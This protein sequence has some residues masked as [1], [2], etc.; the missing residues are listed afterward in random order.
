[1]RI[2]PTDSQSSSFRIWVGRA[3]DGVDERTFELPARSSLGTIQFSPDGRRLA[4][5]VGS[6]M[7]V[8]D[9]ET[10]ALLGNLSGGETGA[11]LGRPPGGATW[12]A[13]TPGGDRLITASDGTDTTPGRVTVWDIGTGREL[14]SF[15]PPPRERLVRIPALTPYSL[16]GARLYVTR[17]DGVW[18]YDG[19]PVEDLH[20][21]NQ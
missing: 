19:T 8:W 13:F 9:V 16:E 11:S 3:A 10:G 17:S 21:T 15:P 2:G 5:K 14:I 12:A 18:V 1:M 6:D 20:V 7:F 4:A